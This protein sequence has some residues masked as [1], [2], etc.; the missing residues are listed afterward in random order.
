MQVINGGGDA[1]NVDEVKE[2]FF[3][4][5]ASNQNIITRPHLYDNVTGERVGPLQIMN[6]QF[7]ESINT[8]TWVNV[9]E[10]IGSGNTSS[11]I[12]NTS[13]IMFADGTNNLPVATS[14]ATIS[15]GLLW[16]ESAHKRF[17]TSTLDFDTTTYLNIQ[18]YLGQCGKS[19]H[20][21]QLIML[22]KTHLLCLVT[23]YEY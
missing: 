4:L 23:I 20:R 8:S 1:T 21:W 14:P 16:E 12:L 2:A 7:Y 5:D 19:L 15:I 13:A 11:L 9:G 22:M 18:L 6:F 17:L 10:W 3:S